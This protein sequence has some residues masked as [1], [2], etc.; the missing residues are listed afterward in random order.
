MTKD[1]ATPRQW[2]VTEGSSF[3]IENKNTIIGS[4]DYDGTVK[5]REAKA[6]AKLIVKAV[7]ER[8]EHLILLK[9]ALSCMKNEN[10]SLKRD[11]EQALSRAEAKQ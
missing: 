7:N 2:H 11:I 8:E 3:Y 5:E 9:W 4:I 1:N 6:N 10:T